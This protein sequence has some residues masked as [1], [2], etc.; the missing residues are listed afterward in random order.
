MTRL[1]TKF[2]GEFVNFV[3]GVAQILSTKM[4]LGTTFIDKSIKAIE[5]KRHIEVP[6]IDRSV[7]IFTS[8][9]DTTS[10]HIGFAETGKDEEDAICEVAK[11]TAIP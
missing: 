8:F 9:M 3:F 1:T 6:G 11:L 5:P 2:G 7:P 4:I 10:A